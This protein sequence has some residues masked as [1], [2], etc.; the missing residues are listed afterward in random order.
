MATLRPN[1]TCIGSLPH[2]N[3]DAALE[4]SFRVGIPFLPQIPVRN[5][6]EYM[7]PQALE[8]LPGLLVDPDG[9]IS[10]NVEVWKS[11]RKEFDAQIHS[12]L[13]KDKR[14]AG[15]DLAPFEPRPSVSSTWQPFLWELTER[16]AP[17][18]KVQI[19]GPLT[20]QWSLRFTGT[21]EGS[22]E[23]RAAAEAR[24][25]VG[26]AIFKLVL[27]RAIAMV[28]KLRA[29]GIQ[30]VVY[31]DEPG[32]YG[33]SPQTNA[34]HASGLEELRLLI[35]TLRKEGAVTGLHCCSNTAWD[36]VLGLA[37]NLL[38]IDV[39]LSLAN[40]LE[41]QDSLQSFLSSGGRL[42]LGVIP[43]ARSSV[44]ASLDVKALFARMLD[45]FG[46][47]RMG[48]EHPEQVKKILS[49][50]IFT[51]ACGLALHSVADA[52]LVLGALLD[53]EGYNFRLMSER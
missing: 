9:T 35:L 46:R 33:L 31:I 39:E 15:A 18:A 4:F 28:R 48:K 47:S 7:L 45:T 8:G 30:P 6:W 34:R 2:H 25:E 12:A 24:A 43:T 51:P 37:P 44:L 5:P 36:A 53:L 10:L 52:E 29:N 32:L 22:R 50:A 13:E 19:A 40:L 1:T 11:R 27:A 20:T 3:V 14:D 38:S 21:A 49:E 42:S 17:M 16:H 23:A 41:H 26:G